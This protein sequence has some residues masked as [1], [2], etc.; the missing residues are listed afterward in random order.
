MYHTFGSR[1]PYLQPSREE[2]Q[3][4][5][6]ESLNRA[7]KLTTLDNVQDGCFYDLI[8]QLVKDPFEL[9]GDKVQLWV[10]DYTE[11]S[12][13]YNHAWTG[14]TEKFEKAGDEYGYTNRYSAPPV[15]NDW[16]GPYGRRSLKMTC[17]Q[18][19]A[20]V[21]RSNTSRGKWVKLMNVQVKYGANG[22]NLEGFLRESPNA[23][24][25]KI[26]VQPL[27]PKA[28]PENL[29]P[30]L[31]EAIRRRYVYE[32]E[33]KAQTKEIH[34]EVTGKKRK[35]PHQVTQQP[36]AA[37]DQRWKP[38]SKRR[39]AFN[40]YKKQQKEQDVIQDTIGL[41]PRGKPAPLLAI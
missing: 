15:K 24:R 34:A 25:G 6:L 36:T 28:D 29:D 4:M 30:R 23:F 27:D 21:L 39:R 41:N 19:H 7:Q 20:T 5:A 9:E 16:P 8:V 10:T 11:N 35:A 31:K 2:F 14:H 22:K 32:K 1:F 40:R 13:F 38:S 17:Y 18:P 33:K 3:T 26:Q 37:Q 12:G